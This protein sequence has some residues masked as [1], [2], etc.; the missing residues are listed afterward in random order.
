[1]KG[2]KKKS[3]SA[4]NSI[5]YGDKT[6]EDYE[7][8]N[9]FSP[10]IYKIK[11]GVLIDLLNKKEELKKR[12]KP[13]ILDAYDNVNEFDD[14]DDLEDFGNKVATYY[15]EAVALLRNFFEIREDEDISYIYKKIF[16]FVFN[17]YTRDIV[18]PDDDDLEFFITLEDTYKLNNAN[19]KK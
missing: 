15:E 10:F 1:M 8:S 2:R 4:V 11:N 14:I 3:F 5:Y 19:V 18:L 13:N 17:I 9:D 7:Y 16:E 12:S 6:N